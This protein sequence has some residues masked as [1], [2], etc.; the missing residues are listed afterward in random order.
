MSR[1]KW[2]PSGVQVAVIKESAAHRKA[3]LFLLCYYYLLTAIGLMP[4]GSVTKIGRTYK[5]WTCIAKETKHTTHEETAYLAK[6]HSTVQV[7]RTE[8]ASDYFWLCG[9]GVLE[10][11][12]STCLPYD[13]VGLWTV[14]VLNVFVLARIS[15][16]VVGHRGHSFGYA[17]KGWT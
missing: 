14:A 11:L 4:G 7:Q 16:M 5:K 15:C 3:V 13:F 10:E 8:V 12:P 17:S 6:F 2:P 1:P 9:L